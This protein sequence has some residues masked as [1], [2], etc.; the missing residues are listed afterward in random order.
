[1]SEPQFEISFDVLFAGAGPANLSAAYYLKQLINKHNQEN[2]DNQIPD[3]MIGV[4]EKGEAVGD[5]I[6]SGAVM[7][8]G[9]LDEL[10]L[11]WRGS[12]IP[13][14]TEVKKDG[15]YFLT[16]KGQFRFPVPPPGM[17]NHGNYIISLTDFVKWLAKKCEAEGV[18]VLTSEPVKEVIYSEEGKII[19]IKTGDKG[20]DKEGTPKGNHMPGAE[21]GVK[22][23]VLGEGSRG[24]VTQ[25]LM[26]KFNLNKGCSPQNYVTGVKELWEVK[27]ENFSKGNIIH[28]FGYPLDFK[29]FGGS[30]LY[31]IK[32]NTVALG[33]AIGLDYENPKL[34]IQEE[35]QKFKK[36]PLIKKT[37]EGGKLIEYGAKTISEGGYYSIGKL[38]GDG[39]IITG[40]G[41]GLL[42]AKKLKGIHLAIKS[43]II[44]AQTLFEAIKSGDF[45]DKKLSLYDHRIKSSWIW[46]ELYSVRN[47]HQSFS[48][49]LI[50]GM[51]H[52]G[53]QTVTGGRGLIDRFKT[54]EDYLH[55]KKL[56]QYI[57]R[58]KN[59]VFKPDGELTFDR[60]TEVYS[61]GVKHEEDQPCH[62]KIEDLSICNGKCVEEYGNPCTKFCPAEVYEIE[63]ENGKK[64]LKMNPS[65]CLHCKT[66]EIKDPYNQ[67]EWSPPEG[68]GGPGYKNM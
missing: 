16:K 7:E 49:G 1:M 57:D 4:F 43:G 21:I 56:T 2:P 20:L 46:K 64:Q 67:I 23:L 47:F 40:E 15:M 37:L 9:V 52:I 10:M 24:Y 62:L 54:E 27:P 45:S 8:P 55:M 19:G 12:D 41:A 29:T 39:F 13:V 61:S 53:L 34:N 66:C 65:N 18:E 50:A 22:A 33:L 30:F 32:D 5:H 25:K 31:H 63:E 59:G 58:S 14:K 36:H 17:D 3:L 42:N 68:G 35:L 11:H 44:A 6:L 60:L 38:S 28:T 51:M 48:Q 26:D